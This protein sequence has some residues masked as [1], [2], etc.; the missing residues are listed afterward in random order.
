MKHVNL[1]LIPIALISFK[2][3][4]SDSLPAKQVSIPF[5]NEAILS[6]HHSGLSFNY[7]MDHN[8]LNK[9]IVCELSNNYKSWFEF[10][11]QGVA[12]ESATFGGNHNVIFISNTHKSLSDNYSVYHADTVGDMKINETSNE[13]AMA[14]ASCFYDYA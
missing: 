3:A 12:T 2:V 1:L 5:Y 4:A 11:N 13:V 8:Q 10:K 7:D 14:T 9:K 6:T